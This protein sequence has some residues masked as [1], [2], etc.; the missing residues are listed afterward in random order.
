MRDLKGGGVG[1]GVDKLGG[2]GLVHNTE[3]EFLKNKPRSLCIRWREDRVPR[4]SRKEA[5]S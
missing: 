4:D 2:D 1:R 3:K 5:I